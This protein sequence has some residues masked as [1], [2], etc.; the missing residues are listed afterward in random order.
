ML[1]GCVIA[2]LGKFFTTVQADLE[3]K[4]PAF[5]VCGLLQLGESA[6]DFQPP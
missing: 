1:V 4:Q 2:N 5:D 6:P 3:A